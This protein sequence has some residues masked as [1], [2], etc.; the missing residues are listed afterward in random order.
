MNDFEQI[1][2]ISKPWCYFDEINE[3]IE[4]YS[5]HAF[6]DASKKAFCSVI[7]LVMKI[8][9]GYH[10]KLVTSK[11]RVVPLKEVSRLELI[12]AL[13]LARLSQALNLSLKSVKYY[14]KKIQS[15]EEI[16]IK[17]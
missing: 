4:Q 12:A 17:M 10:C 3:E 16:I 9:S 14:W 7:Y 13:I 2:C 8:A 6:G 15:S 5:L 11:S 1:L